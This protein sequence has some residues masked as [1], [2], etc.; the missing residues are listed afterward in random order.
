MIIYGVYNALQ[1][2]EDSKYI[3]LFLSKENAFKFAENTKMF[4]GELACFIAVHELT[5]EE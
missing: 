1:S 5:V 3:K 2:D 4:M